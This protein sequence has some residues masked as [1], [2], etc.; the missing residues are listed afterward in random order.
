MPA[1]ESTRSTT[2]AQPLIAAR[3]LGHAHS[4]RDGEK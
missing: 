4:P 2:E 1:E 3:T